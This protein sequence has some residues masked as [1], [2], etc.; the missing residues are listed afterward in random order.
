MKDNYILSIVHNLSP[1][2]LRPFL[3]TLRESGFAGRLVLFIG[4]R[5]LGADWKV[6]GLTV[7]TVPF[8]Y[9]SI[10]MRQPTLMFWPLIKVAFKY[11]SGKQR[12]DLARKTF[13][14]FFLRFLLAYEYL[15]EN[16]E[17]IANVLLTDCRDVVFQRDPF[18]G[19]QNG[20]F[21]YLEHP[22]RDIASCPSNRRMITD[23][24]GEEILRDYGDKPI[25]CA[26][27]TLGDVESVLEYCRI[28]VEECFTLKKMRMVPGSDQGLHNYLV[29]SGRLP[30]MHLVDNFSGRVFT[31]GAVPAE[32]IQRNDLGEVIR[33]NGEVIPVLHQYDRNPVL[34]KF[35]WEKAA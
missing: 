14:L 3:H 11:L 29:H 32:E 13:N 16:R 21:C 24:Y 23:C 17:R 31:M 20:L 25:S 10:R 12:F 7:E 4:G 9:F 34:K 27:V 5:S 28:F 2:D 8:S 33:P 6:D 26:G 15:A 18:A 35:F 30:G 1:S 19:M 22:G